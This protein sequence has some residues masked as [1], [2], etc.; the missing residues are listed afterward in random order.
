[1]AA[2]AVWPGGRRPPEVNTRSRKPSPGSGLDARRPASF[3]PL[4]KQLLK[5]AFRAF[6]FELVRSAPDGAGR[7]ADYPDLSPAE[8]ATILA[9]QPFTMT[10]TE[11]MVAL[12]QAV[13]FVSQNR[14]PGDI[15][16]CGVWRGGSMV[17]IARTL[18]ER[19]DVG[20][21]LYLYDTFEGMPPPADVD[22]SFDGR[23]AQAQ[24]DQT[25]VGE[26]IWARAGLE[27]VRATVLATG[28]PADRIQFS[29]GRVGGHH[30][31]DAAGPPRAAAARHGLVRVDAA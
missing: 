7:F 16:E 25:P 6:G 17:V 19:G 8:K 18:L 22:R 2:E 5:R 9:A 10:G 23:S 1:M 29:K 21:T 12:I 14:I 31:P 3:A 27:A 28:H 26:G 24:M 15:V 13:N 11:R 30:S 20:R 4:V